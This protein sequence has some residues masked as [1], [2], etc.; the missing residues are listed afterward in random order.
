METVTWGGMGWLPWQRV[1]WYGEHTDAMEMKRAAGGG[2]D[3]EDV[4]KVTASG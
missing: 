3:N 4:M 1:S 2:S